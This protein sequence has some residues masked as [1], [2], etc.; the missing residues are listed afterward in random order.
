MEASN[1]SHPTRTQLVGHRALAPPLGSAQSSSTADLSVPR[2]APNRV[3][4]RFASFQHS[5]RL[6][7]RAVTSRT[8]TIYDQKPVS[9]HSQDQER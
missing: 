9:S 1:R 2:D 3:S 7:K 5:A 6:S 8:N 4:P